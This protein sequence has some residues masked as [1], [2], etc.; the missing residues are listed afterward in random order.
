MLCL[1]QWNKPVLHSK[2]MLYLDQWNKPVLH[3]KPKCT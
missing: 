1:D 2:P 3:S